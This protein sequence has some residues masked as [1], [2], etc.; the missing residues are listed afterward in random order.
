MA[1]KSDPAA[2]D[3]TPAAG[4]VSFA[5]LGLSAA[6]LEAVGRMGFETATPVQAASGAAYSLPLSGHVTYLT[7]PAEDTLT[8]GPT[9]DY[10]TDLAAATAGATA[11]GKPHAGGHAFT[12]GNRA[13]DTEAAIAA[14]TADRRGQNAGC[15][16]NITCVGNNISG[17][18][19][20]DSTGSG[21]CAARSAN[22]E[23]GRAKQR[24]PARGNKA[25]VAATAADGLREQNRRA[26]TGC[27]QGSGIIDRHTA[28][29]VTGSARP[30][31]RG[32]A[33]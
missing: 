28:A 10:G 11:D 5:S 30:A 12:N 1:H 20:V 33:G 22:A 23:A 21:P 24:Q 13:D 9:E 15:I 6:V 26:A 19:H 3:P 2:A 18:G 25:A 14:A 8:V 29:V 16:A 4:R 7:Y 17:I 27:G 31:N 32:R